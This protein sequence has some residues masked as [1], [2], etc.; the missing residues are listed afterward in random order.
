[1]GWGQQQM[2]MIPMP[3]GSYGGF[4]DF[5]HGKKG[6]GKGEKGAKGK[7]GKGQAQGKGMDMMMCHPS[8]FTPDSS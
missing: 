1:M 5:S 3:M 4:P 6:K 2:T 7:G 8:A